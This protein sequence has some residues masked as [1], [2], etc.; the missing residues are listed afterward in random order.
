MRSVNA[1]LMGR[2]TFDTLPVGAFVGR[3]ILVMTRTQIAGINCFNN[4]DELDQFLQTRRYEYVWAIGGQETFRSFCARYAERIEKIVEMRL[5]ETWLTDR[6]VRFLPKYRKKFSMNVI[7]E[8]EL[9]QIAEF[10]SLN[11]FG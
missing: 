11:V 5:K 9:I 6:D 3:E 1:V 4:F 2:R 8:D 7:F 10:D